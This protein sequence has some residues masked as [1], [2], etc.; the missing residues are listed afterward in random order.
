MNKKN[1]ERCTALIAPSL[2]AREQI[3]TIEVVQIGKVSA[4]RQIGTAVAAGVLSGGTLMVAV[5][6]RAYFLILTDLRLFLV[7]NNN[8]RVGKKVLAAVPRETIQAGPL[9]GHLLTLSMEV[10]MGGTPYRFG[11]GRAQGKMARRVA[12]ALAQPVRRPGAAP[13]AVTW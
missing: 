12:E 10:T 9:R 11:W 2:V 4:K 6:P 5:R 7:D 1:A 3:Q 13:G 8:G